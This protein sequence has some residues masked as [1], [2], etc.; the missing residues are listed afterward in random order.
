MRNALYESMQLA[1]MIYDGV[2][3]S[4]FKVDDRAGAMK[5]AK[6]HLDKAKR[7][8]RDHLKLQGNNHYENYANGFI[9]NGGGEFDYQW[10]KVFF[11][12][13]KWTDEEK[14]EFVEENWIYCRPSQ[15]DCTGQIF[16]TG[17]D[18]FNVPRGVVV[19]I[20]EAMD[21]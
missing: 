14:A 6:E 15:Y 4:E 16:T 8:Y 18:C 21:V 3:S 5:K 7:K 2:K 17:I 12:G 20:R 1:Q 19:Y 10:M 13:E 9:I 11:P